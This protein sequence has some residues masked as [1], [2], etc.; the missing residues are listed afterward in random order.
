MNHFSL[1]D[2]TRQ[3]VMIIASAHAE[4]FAFQKGQTQA[5]V[6]ERIRAPS[7][8]RFEQHAVCVCVCVWV[9]KLTAD[10]LAAAA[11]PQ[12][13]FYHCGPRVSVQQCAASLHLH[14]A[15]KHFYSA[16]N[17][18]VRVKTGHYSIH[19]SFLAT[20]LCTQSVDSVP[21]KA[22]LKMIWLSSLNG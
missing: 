1:Q 8:W 20:I 2:R 7:F 9:E 12:N 15:A 5:S 17:A 21:G 6:E 3:R 10:L 22:H 4:S 13:P 19:L 14:A 16:A 11:V 18:E